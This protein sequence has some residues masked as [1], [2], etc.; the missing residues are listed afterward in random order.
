M[1]ALVNLRRS[2]KVARCG[3]KLESC[4]L[5]THSCHGC[6]SCCIQ[7][8]VGYL[9]VEGMSA[10]RYRHR[11]GQGGPHQVSLA[12]QLHVAHCCARNNST[13]FTRAS[14]ELHASST[15][16]LDHW[17]RTCG[18]LA[19]LPPRC[20]RASEMP[21]RAFRIVQDLGE[22]LVGFPTGHHARSPWSPWLRPCR[23]WKLGDSTN[24]VGRVD[25]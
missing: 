25:N 22:G 8:H 5:G 4:R 1:R 13:S 7:W 23:R 20:C 9:M 6:H 24:V 11:S 17:R 15:I 12:L 2:P 3:A 21:R 19:I 10:S 18:A 16:I 14:D